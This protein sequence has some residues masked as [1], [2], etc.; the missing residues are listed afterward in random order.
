MESKVCT[1]CNIENLL[2]ISTTNIP[3]EKIVMVIE[4]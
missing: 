2:K 1:P 4:V 3:N